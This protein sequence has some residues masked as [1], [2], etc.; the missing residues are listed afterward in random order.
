VLALAST[1]GYALVFDFS[2]TNTTGTV[3][4]TVMGE[5]DGLVNN[6][7]N[8]SATAV[9][10]TSAPSF[11]NAPPPPFPFSIPSADFV[12]NTFDVEN[13]SITSVD[14]QAS[15]NSNT[16]LLFNTSF[17]IGASLSNDLTNNDVNTSD[18]PT[19]TPVPGPIVGAGLPGLILACGGLLGWWRRRR[20]IA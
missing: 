2:F 3:S 10:I 15:F 8:Q 1:P 12:T 16:L 9:S 17:T 11:L 18:P 19:F 4:G 20:K 13:G 5:I 7:A 6:T 14:F